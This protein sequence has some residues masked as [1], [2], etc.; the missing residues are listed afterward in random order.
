MQTLRHNGL[1]KFASDDNKDSEKVF[2]KPIMKDKGKKQVQF[3]RNLE[4]VETLD[5]MH[6][7]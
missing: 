7:L 1:P 6:I 2:K 3:S 4:T 5:N